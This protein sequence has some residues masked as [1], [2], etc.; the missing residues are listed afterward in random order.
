MLWMPAD[1]DARH[2]AHLLRFGLTVSLCVL[3]LAPLQSAATLAL[4]SLPVTCEELPTETAGTE[5]T[6]PQLSHHVRRQCQAARLSH[7]L[8]PFCALAHVNRPGHSALH[9][10]DLFEPSRP[11]AGAG[12]RA[13]C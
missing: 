6:A 11:H 3:L 8:I 4:A 2:S 1:T 5:H 12:V 10:L 9:H 7:S 13:R